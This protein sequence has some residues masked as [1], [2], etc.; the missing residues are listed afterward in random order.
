MRHF[1]II[2][3]CFFSVNY[4]FAQDTVITLSP[5]MFTGV[6]EITICTMDGWYFKEGHDTALAQKDIDITSWK[7]LKPTELTAKQA[8]KNGRLEGWLRFKFI[9]DD[10]FK[11]EQPG[12]L[13]N[14][15]AAAD[16]YID[17]VLI[18]SFGNT[19]ADNKPFK[20]FNSLYQLP[21]YAGLQ[22]GIEHTIAMHFTDYVSPLPPFTLMSNFNLH[23][24]LLLTDSEFYA[25]DLW[26]INQSPVYKTLWVS[27]TTVL[28]LLFW[29]L[30]FLNR[31]ERNLLLFA[32]CST[33]ISL[34]IYLSNSFFNSENS[35]VAATLYAKSFSLFYTLAGCI[36]IIVVARV[37][38]NKV[39]A[40]LKVILLGYIILGVFQ[41]L[42]VNPLLLAILSL[43]PIIVY[44]WFIV[45]SWKL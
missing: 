19:G 36:T 24:L 9:L 34:T 32:I 7:K 38:K 35:F 25:Y 11:N 28:T 29:L 5:V 15:W 41:I 2:I 40:V 13:F 17:G 26:L 8:D 22:P 30:A 43:I 45:S 27:V 42:F 10:A 3:L 1:F 4:S 37:F 20:E 21:F 23:R 31:R 6:G 16:I 12:F 14:G 39:S 44:T 33:L 18:K